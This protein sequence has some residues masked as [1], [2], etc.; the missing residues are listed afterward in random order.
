MESAPVLYTRS[1]K[2]EMR[3][4][5]SAF[6]QSIERCSI[7]PRD[8]AALR[9]TTRAQNEMSPTEDTP[10]Y[11]LTGHNLSGSSRIVCSRSD[12]RKEKSNYICLDTLSFVLL[13]L[14]L[15]R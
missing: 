5:L 1:Y 7:R 4:H 11:Q 13:L 15:T 14:C 2:R 3:R 9:Q 8:N 10:M 6:S 12:N